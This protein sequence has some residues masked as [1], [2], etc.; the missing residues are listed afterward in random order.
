MEGAF[1]LSRH[2][3][4]VCLVV[5]GNLGGGWLRTQELLYHML[6]QI[7]LIVYFELASNIN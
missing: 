3:R 5:W 2:W 6:A 1:N 4:V 7:F